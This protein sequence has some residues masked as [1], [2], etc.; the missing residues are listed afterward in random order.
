M[1]TNTTALQ[2][3]PGQQQPVVCFTWEEIQDLTHH[4]ARAIRAGGLPDV[5]IGLQRGGLIPAVML[6]HQLAISTVLALP[7]RRTLSD[8][9]Y[10]PKQTPSVVLPEHLAQIVGKD[11]VV[12]DDIVGSGE[13]LSTALQLLATC[14]PARVRSV[15]CVVNRAHWDPVHEDEPA[16]VIFSIGKEARAWVVFPWEISPL[17]GNTSVEEKTGLERN[18][19]NGQKRENYGSATER[20]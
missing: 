3:L 19:E 18:G 11:I 7:I 16:T 10:A 14:A 2:K 9:I 12:V 13:T 15:V 20:Y 17:P 6:S 5:L 4:L 1:D 8:A